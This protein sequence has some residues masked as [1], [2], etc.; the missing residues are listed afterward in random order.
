MRASRLFTVRSETWWARTRRPCSSPSSTYATQSFRLRVPCHA[1]V[2]P[3]TCIRFRP[4]I[5]ASGLRVTSI[6]CLC[7][8]PSPTPPRRAAQEYDVPFGLTRPFGSNLE[9]FLHECHVKPTRRDTFHRP[10]RSVTPAYC[11]STVPGNHSA[12][13][14]EPTSLAHPLR[15]GR[16][17][18]EWGMRLTSLMGFLA[19]DLAVDLGTANTLVY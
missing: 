11:R 12:S 10:R 2:N 19:D 16:P 15:P 8:F 13:S 1:T 17:R 9:Q 5:F 3:L 4:S 6:R 7:P 14:R 18:K